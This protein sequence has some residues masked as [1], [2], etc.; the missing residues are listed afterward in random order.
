MSPSHARRQWPSSWSP[1]CSSLRPGP[2]TSCL[3]PRL[4][5]S[6]TDSPRRCPRRTR[7]RGRR[8]GRGGP[9][10][11]PRWLPRRARCPGR[12]RV[13]RCPD[14]VGRADRRT[15]G[16]SRP[17]RRRAPAGPVACHRQLLAHHTGIGRYRGWVWSHFL[18]QQLT[19]AGERRPGTRA[20][21]GG[22]ARLRVPGSSPSVGRGGRRE[23]V[24]KCHK[25]HRQRLGGTLA[26]FGP[27]AR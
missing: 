2:S 10:R 23:R 17:V 21:A 19:T 13:P 24:G 14:E 18:R 1:A 20:Y 16:R 3:C 15:R 25:A 26:P 11:R 4:G 27:L 7:R 5:A 8:R 12:R 6:A 22:T 9:E